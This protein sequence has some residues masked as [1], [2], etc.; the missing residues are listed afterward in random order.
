MDHSSREY[1]RFHAASL[2]IVAGRDPACHGCPLLPPTVDPLVA[3]VWRLWQAA[4]TQWRQGPAGPTGLDYP[5]V[6]QLTQQLLHRRLYHPWLFHLIQH[7]ETQYLE[8]FY[9]RRQAELDRL[10]QQSS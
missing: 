8:L 10:R 6:D 9:A 4:S 3:P 5:A 7:L 1:C 2:Q